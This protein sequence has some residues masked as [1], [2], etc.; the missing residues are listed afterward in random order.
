MELY[1]GEKPVQSHL[2]LMDWIKVLRSDSVQMSL[3]VF[4]E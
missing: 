3:S 2:C 4:N 1:L